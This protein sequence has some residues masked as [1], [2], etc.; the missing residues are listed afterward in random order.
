M[1]WF[2]SNS[3]I[4]SEWTA[5]YYIL[6]VLL[7]SPIAGLGFTLGTSY[8]YASID[9]LWAVRFIAFAIGY[10]IFIPL[11]WWFFGESPFTIK[12][13]IS[14][15]LCITLISVQVLWK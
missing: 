10:L 13:V 7:L 8:L 5:K 2:S 1:G 12:N 6:I 14:M 4:I 3:L 9:E 15:L 11:T